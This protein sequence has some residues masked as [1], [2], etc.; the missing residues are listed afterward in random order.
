MGRIKRGIVFLA[1]AVVFTGAV[2]KKSARN[3]PAGGEEA[4]MEEEFAEEAESAPKPAP[5]KVT[6]EIYIELTVQS[7][8]TREKLKDDPA[9]AELEIEA[10]FEKAGVTPDEYKEFER[11]LAPDKLN[12]L[13]KKIQEKLQAFI[14]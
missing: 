3:V 7:I 5:P 14:R 6:D 10:L 9:A 11:K 13:Q 8:V 1:L 12:D 2:C 4:T